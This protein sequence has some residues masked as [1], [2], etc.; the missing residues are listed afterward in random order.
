MTMKTT[1]DGSRSGSTLNKEIAGK[2]ID[3][4][5]SS[6]RALISAVRPKHWIKNL[7]IIAPLLFAEK[8]FDVGLLTKSLLAFIS[9]SLVASSIYLLNDV[10]D[11]KQDREHPVKRHRAIASGRIKISQA[12][13]SA[14]ILLSFG[15]ATAIGVN[16]EFVI[17]AVGYVLLNILYSTYLKHRVII[18]VLALSSFYVVRVV[19]GGVATGIK[20][21]NWLL[22]CTF[23]LALFMS[24]GKR[25]HEITLLKDGAKNHRA[26]LSEYNPYFLDQMIAVVT[27]STLVAYSLYTMSQE[28]IERFHTDKLPLTI[29]FVLYGIFRYL[30]LVHQKEEGGNPTNLM[31]MDKPLILTVVGWVAAVLLILY[32]R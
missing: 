8:L 19:A 15:L 24:F 11:Y 5:Q 22:I 7:F 28:T 21:S 26:I 13:Y 29:P 17:V 20:L 14:A 2:P 32:L 3:L 6:A 1:H 16:L 18:D 12:A 31:L 27:S 25:R 4:S 9:F 10:L 23:L 30:Y